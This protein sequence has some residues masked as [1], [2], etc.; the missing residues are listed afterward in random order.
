MLPHLVRISQ[1]YTLRFPERQRII[2]PE[3]VDVPSRFGSFR[4]AV[5]VVGRVLKV[6]TDFRLSASVISVSDYPEF[7]RWIT[8]VR[9]LRRELVEVDDGLE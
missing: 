8:R 4:V 9:D 6:S 2:P 3:S 7:R 1:D 5:D